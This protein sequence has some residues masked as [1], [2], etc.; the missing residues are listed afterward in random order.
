MPEDP[1]VSP[2]AKPVRPFLLGRNHAGQWVV[3]D[4]GGMWGG[5]FIDRSAAL[6]FAMS[7]NGRPQAVIMVPY[8]L[9]L[10]ITA[11]P[12]QPVAEA[13]QARAARRRAA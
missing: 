3:R 12:E 9:E 2:R 5:V 6:K 10:D 7:E 11:L 8:I 1:A 4:E 13:A